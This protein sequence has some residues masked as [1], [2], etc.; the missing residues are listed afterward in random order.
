M[1]PELT[2]AEIENRNLVLEPL[3]RA[4][5]PDVGLCDCGE[6][7]SRWLARPRSIQKHSLMWRAGEVHATGW[8][9]R[10]LLRPVVL[11]G[12]S[13]EPRPFHTSM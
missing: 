7:R 9:D 12:R 5:E 6:V 8:E 1:L 10:R 11:G 13:E 3:K 2:T 4:S